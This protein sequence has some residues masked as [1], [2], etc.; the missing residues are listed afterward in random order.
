MQTTPDKRRQLPSV[1]PHLVNNVFVR[2]V[3]SMCFAIALAV[4][5]GLTSVVLASRLCAATFDRVAEIVC[6][7]LLTA[8]HSCMR[9]LETLRKGSPR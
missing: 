3:A 8:M 9:T 6:D 5:V 4:M 7:G 2:G 1:G